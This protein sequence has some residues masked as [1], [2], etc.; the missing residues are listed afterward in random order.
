MIN[1][2]F[3]KKEEK[4]QGRRLVAPEEHTESL[5]ALMDAYGAA[6]TGQDRVAKYWLWKHIH[7]LFPETI[8]GQWKVT[9]KATQVIVE[10]VV[11]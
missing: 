6:P 9:G 3:W 2:K 1:W 4:K 10:E 5:L 11:E 7:S 8:T